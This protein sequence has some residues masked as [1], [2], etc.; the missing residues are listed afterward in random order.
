MRL[1]LADVDSVIE[2][3]KYHAYGQGEMDDAG[4]D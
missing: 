4:W 1:L 3:L 2:M